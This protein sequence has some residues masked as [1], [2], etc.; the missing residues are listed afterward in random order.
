M[1]EMKMHKQTS[2]QVLETEINQVVKHFNPVNA[3]VLHM[4]SNY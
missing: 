1:N 4:Y 3:R 2:N